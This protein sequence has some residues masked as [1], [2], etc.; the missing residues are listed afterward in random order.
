MDFYLD[1][2]EGEYSGDDELKNSTRMNKNKNYFST[3]S[4]SPL[5]E[6]NTE[7]DILS[8]YDIPMDSWNDESNFYDA[9]SGLPTSYFDDEGN[10]SI[11]D[12]TLFLTGKAI[13]SDETLP[14]KDFIISAPT[15][16][17]A[18]VADAPNSPYF[19][20]ISSSISPASSPIVRRRF[21]SLKE[22]LLES[23]HK[24]EQSMR[25]P[26]PSSLQDEDELYE[27][28]ELGSVIGGKLLEDIDSSTKIDL[29]SSMRDD[30][31]NDNVD[32]D[33]IPRPQSNKKLT[34]KQLIWDSEEG[35]EII[36]KNKPISFLKKLLIATIFLFVILTID[37]VIQYILSDQLIRM[38]VD[39]VKRALEANLSPWV[40][41]P[42]YYLVNLRDVWMNNLVF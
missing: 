12:G 20:A 29:L 15:K 1:S 37:L 24:F 35:L 3:I 41:V 28:S 14:L 13:N 6:T 4:N 10:R 30:D 22:D 36:R 18:S 9:P 32:W 16:Q 25:K 38:Y 21:D 26:F 19:T 7:E 33:I 11:S 2:S 27:I 17:S 31:D 8:R 42:W 39:D 34:T 5:K 23:K 40:E